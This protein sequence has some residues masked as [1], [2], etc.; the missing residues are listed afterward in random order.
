MKIKFTCHIKQH[1]GDIL[2][3]CQ[4]SFNYNLEKLSFAVS[5]GVSQAYRPELWSRVLTEAY[6][7]NP[8]TFFIQDSNNNFVINSKL[9]LNSK[10]AAAESLAYKNATPQEQFVLDMKKNS[11]NISAATF[12][13]VKLIEEGISFQTIG[14]SVLFFYDYETRELKAYSSMMPESGEMTFNN[15][16][17]YIDSNE[18][19]HGK[20][21]SGILPY[22]KGIL[23]MATD[24]LSDWIVERHEPL[25]NIE[26]ILKELMLIPTHEAYDLW[27]DCARNNSNPIKLKDDDTTFIAIEFTDITD[28]SKEIEH[29]FTVKFDALLKDCLLS[30]LNS[31]RNELEEI[32]SAKSKS[33]MALRGKEKQISGL[34]T[35]LESSK[36]EIA[37]K[38]TEIV[39]LRTEIQSLNNQINKLKID[40]NNSDAK[41]RRLENTKSSLTTDKNR[42][43]QE[44]QESNQDVLRLQNENKRLEEVIKSHKITPLST[45]STPK[46]DEIT[47]LQSDLNTANARIQM[48][49]SKLETLQEIAKNAR[50][51]YDTNGEITILDI[52]T[53]LTS[54]LGESFATGK[55][56]VEQTI[57]VGKTTGDGGFQ[58]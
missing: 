39:K 17:E 50:S 31:Q 56:Y 15:N 58:M 26:K 21:I 14:D 5:D 1:A 30:E 27:V 53:L 46:E 47:K 42:L 35:D 22:R 3:E 40:L 6:V 4:D 43:T 49:Q 10:W 20:V 28:S 19:N 55:V 33:E 38:N 57:I 9:G 13:G 34:T 24:A 2:L 12:I 48:L 32:K 45:M 51:S 11:I 36:N 25:N 41:C 7:N 8:D 16:P 52:E 37:T 29:N 18:S 44:L 54:I 23:F